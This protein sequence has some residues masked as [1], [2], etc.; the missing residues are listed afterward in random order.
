MSLDKEDTVKFWESSAA[1][2]GSRNLLKDSSAL[3]DRALFH[4]LAHI[5]GKTD[6]IFMKILPERYLWTMKSL[7]N[8]IQNYLAR[9]LYL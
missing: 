9:G 3:Q 8:L 4:N 2:S 5:S 1:G 6:R 7:L